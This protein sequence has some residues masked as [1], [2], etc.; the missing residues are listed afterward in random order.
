MWYEINFEYMTKGI[1]FN[2]ITHSYKWTQLRRWLGNIRTW[3]LSPPVDCT[4]LCM[5]S[6]VWI[7][8][9]NIMYLRVNT[10]NHKL[11]WQVYAM[12]SLRHCLFCQLSALSSHLSSVRLL[13]LICLLSDCQLLAV[14]CQLEDEAYPLCRA[15]LPGPGHRGL[16]LPR[17]GHRHED[18]QPVQGDNTLHSGAPYGHN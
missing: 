1:N 2:C 13:A 15:G 4:Q 14:L 6:Y 17:G 8:S 9:I 16:L 3:G 10:V 7:I 18:H 11:V 5:I 12:S